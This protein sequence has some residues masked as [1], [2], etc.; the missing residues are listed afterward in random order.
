MIHVLF[1][2]QIEV[3][4]KMGDYIIMAV[5]IIRFIEGIGDC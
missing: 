1:Q 2:P 3:S 4:G 5:G